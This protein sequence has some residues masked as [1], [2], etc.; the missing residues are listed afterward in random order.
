MK[1]KKQFL[2]IFVIFTLGFFACRLD[3]NAKTFFYHIK[4]ELVNYKPD[5]I[6][7]YKSGNYLGYTFEKVA[8]AKVEDG[9]FRF[10]GEFYHAEMYYIGISDQRNIPF[11]L[12]SK[13]IFVEGSFEKPVKFEIRGAELNQ[14]LQEIED[15]LDL[16][17]NSQQELE[18]IDA[19]I[20]NKADSPLNPYLILNYRYHIGNFEELNHLYNLMDLSLRSHP[21][22]VRIKSQMDVLELVQQGKLAPEIISR[23]SA[24][25]EKRLSS[26]RGS[27]VLIEFWASWCGPCRAENPGLVKLYKELKLKNANFEILG[28]AAEFDKLPWTN[29]IYEDGLPWINVSLISG[30]DE[31]ALVDYGIKSIPASILINPEG[32]IIARGLEG[33]ELHNK[34]LEILQ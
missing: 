20:Q 23:D 14:Q 4:G 24:G 10:D 22:S 33:E 9:R 17:E 12:N 5:S 30:F 27:Y 15:R 25:N 21:Y 13:E 29:A 8:S 31:K 1:F 18:M 16:V 6:F 28:I 11:Y 34:I 3:N 19:F 7:L 2:F 26:L 32:R